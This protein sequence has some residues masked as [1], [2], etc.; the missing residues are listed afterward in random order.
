MK[1][2]VRN[3]NAYRFHTFCL[4]PR[5][6]PGLSQTNLH[7]LAQAQAQDSPTPAPRVPSTLNS[8]RPLAMPPPLPSLPSE[9][10][11]N[12]HED[13]NN[14]INSASPL[15]S[16]PPSAPL[17]TSGP[18][19]GSIRRRPKFSNTSIT[20]VRGSISGLGSSSVPILS[21]STSVPTTAVSNDEIE[22]KGGRSTGGVNGLTGNSGTTPGGTGSTRIR[23]G[24]LSLRD[25]QER[26]RITRERLGQTGTGERERETGV[27]S[28]SREHDASRNANTLRKRAFS[29]ASNSQLEEDSNLRHNPS[30]LSISTST[31]ASTQSRIRTLRSR[32]RPRMS[33][34]DVQFDGDGTATT[35]MREVSSPAALGT[36]LGSEYEYEYERN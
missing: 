23:S 12:R 16:F 7:L 32:T 14:N 31:S 34:D 20:T 24:T 15:T 35:H 25:L 13:D 6:S 1:V 29:S 8:K 10:L 21:P 11:F 26:D 18:G 2:R 36:R 27:G 5:Q 19:P 28:E 33:L 30:T 3:F 9:S 22:I 17:S 4:A